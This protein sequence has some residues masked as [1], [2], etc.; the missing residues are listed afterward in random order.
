MNAEPPFQLAQLNV[1]RLREPLDHPDSADFVAGLAPMNALA[2]SSPGFVWRLVDDGGA[3]ATALSP[4]EDE[5]IIV[6]M[7]VWESLEALR[8]YAFRSAHARRVFSK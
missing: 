6:N 7:S 1:A 8:S 4:F 3:D 5:R 2:E